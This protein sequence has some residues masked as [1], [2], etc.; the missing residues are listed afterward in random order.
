MTPP[1][2]DAEQQIAEVLRAALTSLQLS[3]A[4]LT[5]MDADTQA[6][7]IVEATGSPPVAE[8]SALPRSATLCQAILDGTFP[9]AIPDLRVVPAMVRV[10]A[11][12]TSSLRSYLSVPV[13][14]SDGTLYGTL[15]AAGQEGDREPTVRD[16]A[17]LEVL[18]RSVATL[19]EPTV[20][21]GDRRIEIEGRLRPL[22]A[23]G[24]PQVLLQPIVDLQTGYRIGAEALSRFPAEWDRPPD[25]CFAEA[26]SVGL[27]HRLEM[28][29]LERAADHLAAVA[30]YVAMNLSPATLLTSQCTVLLSGMALDRI[31]LELSEHDQVSD[32]TALDN[33][34]APLRA[35]G[36]RL[37][38]DDVGAGFSSLR[39]IVLTGPDVIKL[40]RTIVHGVS[41]DPSL[42]TV[43]RSLVEF[44]HGCSASVV[45]EG[46]ESA[47]DAAAL[48]DLGVDHG[49]G[50]H[51]GRP[52]LPADLPA[53]LPPMSPPRR[54]VVDAR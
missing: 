36:M 22:M 13:R 39:H 20:K 10:P 47:A 18:A 52:G 28:L 5:R 2:S 24:G 50:W 44:A 14:L 16:A 17:V 29:A 26:H 27:G 30:G 40:D 42:M 43:V 54:T 33:A 6:V 11:G 21:E 9:V 7:E 25:V 37:A 31:I 48:A 51:F 35:R 19:V 3:A 4:F 38:I 15:C 41:T 49:Q 45:A 8:G 53:Y 46:I 32:Y 23:T 1:R 12:R 34:L